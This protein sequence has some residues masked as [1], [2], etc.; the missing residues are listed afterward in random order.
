[1]YRRRATSLACTGAR[2]GLARTTTQTTARL[3]LGRVATRTLS[4]GTVRSSFSSSRL[5]LA[6]GVTGLGLWALYNSNVKVHAAGP[7][8]PQKVPLTGLPGTKYERTFIAIK[9]DGVQRGL[10]GEIIHRFERRG[11]KLVAI[12][13]VRP[14]KA[15][16]EQHYK[17]LAKKPF[18]PSLV[19][20]FT[21]GPVIAMVWEGKEAVVQGRR[22][23]GATNPSESA[24][25][26]IRG[27]LCLDIGRN[28]IHGSD[29]NESARDE[30]SLWFSE[31][32][33]AN[34]ESDNA[35]WLYG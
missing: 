1:M 14:T 8:E 35:K 17:D 34:W 5:A 21:S 24:P 4:T 13:I 7:S 3:Q 9:P 31:N 30:I 23:V 26:S 19:N 15:F 20:Y 6:A 29:S 16:A 33:I 10:V 11:Y 28:I 32:E 18:F 2:V 22:L 12:K 25:G 27:D